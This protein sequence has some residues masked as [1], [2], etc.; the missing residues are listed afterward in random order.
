MK[1]ALFV[2]S[3]ITIK[4]HFSNSM[5]ITTEPGFEYHSQINVEVPDGVTVSKISY[6]LGDGTEKC[7]MPQDKQTFATST[8]GWMIRSYLTFE[9]LIHY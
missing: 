6:Q 5:V 7:M 3:D 9:Q 4:Y 1:F 2:D 8:A